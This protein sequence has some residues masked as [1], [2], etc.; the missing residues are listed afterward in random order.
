MNYQ[1]IRFEHFFVLVFRFVYFFI[2]M[3]IAASLQRDLAGSM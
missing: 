2:F 3:L 1:E